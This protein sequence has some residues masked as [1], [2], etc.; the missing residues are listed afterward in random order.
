MTTDFEG[1][2]DDGP[3]QGRKAR[4]SD[5]DKGRLTLVGS[6]VLAPPSS[7]MNLPVYFLE[8]KGF[9][10]MLDICDAVIQSCSLHFT[11]SHTHI[12]CH[13]HTVTAVIPICLSQACLYLPQ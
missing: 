3:D 2:S 12:D 9:R 13:F 5:H 11:K 1:A 10:F 4:T 7:S 6:L 8:A